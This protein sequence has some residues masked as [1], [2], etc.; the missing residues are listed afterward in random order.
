MELANIKVET[1]GMVADHNFPCP[2]CGKCTAILGGGHFNPCYSCQAEGLNIVN[3]VKSRPWWI[4]LKL[5]EQHFGVNTS[6]AKRNK[7]F[8]YKET[9][10]VI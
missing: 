8:F 10:S 9:P 4:P 3:L 1:D 5:W 2:C 6:S 7:S